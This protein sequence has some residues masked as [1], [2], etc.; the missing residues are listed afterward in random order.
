MS[1]IRELT[2]QFSIKCEHCPFNKDGHKTDGT[3]CYVDMIIT[4]AEERD[5]YKTAYELAVKDIE[6]LVTDYYRL[7]DDYDGLADN[8]MSYC[9]NN[10]GKCYIQDDADCNK[11]ANWK[12]RHA[13][14]VKEMGI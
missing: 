11:C 7:G 3:E 1:K 9:K 10:N 14:K 8:C 5:A 6:K 12:W 4:A 13:D 2:E